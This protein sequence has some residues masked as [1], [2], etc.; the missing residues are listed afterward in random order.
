MRSVHDLNADILE[1]YIV[2]MILE[3]DVPFV[4]FATAVV[5]KFEG[6]R[7]FLLAELACLEHI[8]P[9]R[10]PQM[11]LYDILTVLAVNYSTLV[12]HDLAVV[13]LAVRLR[14]LRLGRNHVIQGS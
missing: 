5:Q 11:V 8:C 2:S 1:P 13:P 4:V 7:P 10:S 14:V 3:S 12:D 9:L 6:K